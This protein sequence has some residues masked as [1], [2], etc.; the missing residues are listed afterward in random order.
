MMAL[1]DYVD[2]LYIDE[3]YY[4]AGFVS[5][6]PGDTDPEGPQVPVSRVWK[7]QTPATPRVWTPA[8]PTQ[9]R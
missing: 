7:A 2:P 8:T 9:N 6:V 1:T 4:E 5:E 3:G